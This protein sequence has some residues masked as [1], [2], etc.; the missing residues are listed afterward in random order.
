MSTSSHQKPR[1]PCGQAPPESNLKECE[2]CRQDRENYEENFKKNEPDERRFDVS[3]F[4]PSVLKPQ[5]YCEDCLEPCTFCEYDFCKSHQHE[6]KIKW[7]A[8]DVILCDECRCFSERTHHFSHVLHGKILH[9]HK[10]RK[11]GTTVK[12]TGDKLLQ[13]DD[14]LKIF[15]EKPVGEITELSEE[16][17]SMYFET[18]YYVYTQTAGN[19]ENKKEDCDS[20]NNK[21]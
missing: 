18:K 17:R 2:G 5:K 10:Q 19:K 12:E 4:L 6:K 8:F 3:V 1:C 13:D 16:E 11:F 21:K 9:V 14:E 7:I 20:C 15:M